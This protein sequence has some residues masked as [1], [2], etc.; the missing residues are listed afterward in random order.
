VIAVGFPSLS[1]EGIEGWLRCD[2]IVLG[3]LQPQTPSSEEEGA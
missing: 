1:K 2:S 3:G